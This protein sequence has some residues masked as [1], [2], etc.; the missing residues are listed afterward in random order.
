MLDII[1]HSGNANQNH[2]ELSLHISQ[3]GHHQEINTG[4]DLEKKKSRTV[5]GNVDW[6]SHYGK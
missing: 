6:Y 3:N 4:E 1:S 2:N 5:G